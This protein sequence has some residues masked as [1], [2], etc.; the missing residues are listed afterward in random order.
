MSLESRIRRLE[1]QQP[2]ATQPW[3]FIFLK[4]DETQQEGFVRLQAGNPD[5]QASGKTVYF[6]IVVPNQSLRC[7]TVQ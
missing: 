5:T 1:V 2:R 7:S 3:R 4:A 6:K